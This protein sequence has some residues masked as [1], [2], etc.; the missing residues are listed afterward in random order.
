MRRGSLERWA[1]FAVLACMAAPSWAQP[2]GQQPA[3]GGGMDQTPQPV[4]MSVDPNRP[5][6]ATP[7]EGT[8]QFDY[9]EAPLIQVIE[10]FGAKVGKNYEI[11]Q[12][13]AQT[14]V[15][16][17]T[18]APISAELAEEIL[19]SILASHDYT[20]VP[21]LDGN[22][23]KIVKASQGGPERG[24]AEIPLQIGTGPADSYGQ[25]ETHALPVQ[26]A[27][28]EDLQPILEQ[29]GSDKAKVDAYLPTNTL[30]MT[31]V[32]SGINRMKAFL[33]EVDIAGSN[34]V[35]DLF[36]LEYTRAET[37]ATQLTDVLLGPEGG[38]GGAAAANANRQPAAPPIAAPNRRALPG[39][40]R[41][42]Q[43]VGQV[44]Q[45]LRVIH[46]ERLNAVIVVASE[47]LM[48]E[49]RIL[50]SRLDQPTPP[51]VHNMHVYQLLNGDAE[52]VAEALNSMISGTTPQAETAQQGGAPAATAEV[53]AFERK[54]TIT[55]YVETNSMLVLASPQDYSRLRSIIAELDVPLRQ[56]H[57]ESVIMDVIINDNFSLSVN[58]VG[59]DDAHWFG[60]NNAATLA[61]ALV[62]GPLALAGNN[63]ATIGYVDGT[64]EVPIPDGAGGVTTTTIP[65]IPLLVNMVE[66]LTNTDI[67]SQ[68]SLITADNLE[69]TITV[70]Q[71]VPFITGSSSSLDQSAVGR[72]VFNRV[73]REDVGV[74]LTVTP[75]I[76][77]GDYVF[78]NLTVEVSQTVASDIGADVNL[79]GP[80]VQK[81]EVAAQISIKDGSTGIIGGLVS[82]NISQSRNQTPVLGDIPLLGALFRGKGTGRNKRNLVVL[83]T[84][85]IVRDSTD[86]DRLTEYKLNQ[87]ERVNMDVWFE[88]GFLRKVRNKHDA[89][90]KY[91]PSAET[92]DF[93]RG[94]NQ[95]FGRGDME[96]APQ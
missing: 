94:E 47:V 46:D 64:T 92:T 44:Q 73:E 27:S 4:E 53:S 33:Q 39:A 83:V 7:V 48:D 21:A 81:S 15:T 57:V 31:D 68:P 13:A 91:R 5:K 24:G 12:A 17:I 65:N 54:V 75:Q 84:P 23:I 22:L 16:V 55:P 77:E 63:N 35:T 85:T 34:V 66:T 95:Y 50:I 52:K 74:I 8:I 37:V 45:T 89:R 51:D 6:F 87:F 61:N 86:E 18:F 71:E 25:F 72:S 56:V 2:A 70:G 82:E 30:I 80:T 96:A 26:Y 43:V 3:A 40:G 1:A 78:M 49:V 79:V 67:L 76:S 9:R 10:E 32:G 69:A 90:N 62:N 58:S 41:T 19:A 29:L 59:L 28:V 60:F 20:M 42:G 14:T 11:D 88:K 93:Y 36:Q 38:A